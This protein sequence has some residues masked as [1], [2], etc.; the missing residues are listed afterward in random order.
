MKNGAKNPAKDLY[1]QLRLLSWDQLWT[2]H[3]PAF[4]SSDSLS[5]AK[6]AAL[7]RAVGVVFS[8]AGRRSQK[9]NVA[10]WIRS[11]LQDSDEKIRRYAMAALPKIGAGSADEDALIQ[12][13]Q[14]ENHPGREKKYL[15]RALDKIG[16]KATLQVAERLPE[17]TALKVKASMARAE[18]PSEILLDRP[19]NDFHGIQINLRGRRGLEDYVKQEIAASER[20]R[21]LFEIKESRPGIVMLSAKAPFTLSD[22]LSLRCFGSLGIVLGTV[23]KTEAPEIASLITSTKTRRLFAGLTQGAIRYRLE[24]TSLGHQRGLVRDIANQAYA[25]CPDILND[26]RSAPWAVEIHPGGHRFTVELR[27]RLSPDP[28]FFYRRRDVPAAS[29]P[30]LAASMALLAGSS[31]ADVVWDP[32]C[33]SGLELIERGLRGGVRKLLGSDRSAAAIDIAR[34]NLQ[35][36][37]LGV[38]SDFFHG[39][40]RAAALDPNSIS[41]IITN[42]PMG[43]RVPI[44]DLEGLIGDLFQTAAKVLQPGG[45]LVLAN[46]LSSG[47]SNSRLRLDTTRRIDLGGFDVRL[48][49]YMKLDR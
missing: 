18:S 20:V 8:E 16:G 19:V 14:K 46:P 48:E 23:G 42:P 1:K 34:S 47:H 22:V 37:G 36:S 10:A 5:R 26:A 17:Q 4:D 41:Q 43:R 30:P 31:G 33:G 24:F 21:R 40:F 39:D 29:H 45:V 15:A 32:F 13:L 9:D 7:V 6:N 35:A 49:R 25:E 44:P 12:L 3:V 27:P 28:R 38:E 2:E 11:L